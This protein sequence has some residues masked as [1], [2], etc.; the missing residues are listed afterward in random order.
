MRGLGK[1]FEVK[2]K[3]AGFIGLG[4]IGAETAQICLALGMITLGLNE[5]TLP[6]FTFS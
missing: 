1:A 3:K 5:T 6:F 4:A 2:G